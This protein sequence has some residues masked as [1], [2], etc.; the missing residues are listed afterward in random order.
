VAGPY[1]KEVGRLSIRVLPNA[2]KLRF[3]LQKQINRI[4]RS[5]RIE[6]DVVAKTARAQLDVQRF[7]D[8]FDGRDIGMEVQANTEV[9]RAQIAALARTRTISLAVRVR[10][11]TVVKAGAILAQ[12]TGARVVTGLM[13]DLNNTLSNLDKSVG[14]V[15]RMA[16]SISSLTTSLLS[17]SA[18]LITT[19]GDLLKMV[20]VGLVLP[21]ALTG[22]V[23]GIA[24]LGIALGDAKT[25]LAELLPAWESVRNVIRENFW[26]QAK[27]PIV[28]FVNNLLPAFRDGFGATA[29]AIGSQVGTLAN[30]FQRTLGGGV[31]E[32]LFGKLTE[33]ID[34]VTT[35]MKPLAE[36]LTTLGVVGSSY[37]P[38][39]A[40]WMVEIGNS[41]N[42][43]VQEATA[44]GEIFD[45]IE[46]GIQQIKY[47][48]AAVSGLA[49]IF[50]G[51]NSASEAAGFGGLQTFAAA[52]Q[53]AA[54][55]IQSP[56]VQ[57][58]LT[59]ILSG[60]GTAF[61]ALGG[62]LSTLGATIIKLAPV[63][64][65]VLATAGQ[66][67]GSFISAISRA[68]ENKGFTD[69]LLALFDGIKKGAA[70]LEPGL[71]PLAE[72]FGALMTTVGMLAAE[73]G[74]LIAALK[75]AFAPVLET[76]LQVLQPL[77]PI[78]GEAL[79][80]AVQAITPFIEGLAGFIQDNSDSFTTLA[81]V[82]LVLIPAIGLGVKAFQGFGLAVKGTK[83]VMDGVT[84]ARIVA[85][86]GMDVVKAVG[87]SIAA[88]GKF[89]A[90]LATV[91]AAKAADLVL[92]ARIAAMYAADMVKGLAATTAALVKQGAQWVA[93]QA[94]MVAAKAAAAGVAAADLAKS[95]GATTAALVKQ[96]AAWV[97]QKAAM[98]AAKVA[99]VAMTVAQGAAA[100]AQRLLNAAMS[101][102]PIGI[103]ITLIAALVAGLIWFFTQTDAGKAIFAGFMSFISD[104]IA[105]LKVV[106]DAFWLGLGIIVDTVFN[107][108][109][110]AI[111][112]YVTGMTIIFTAIGTTIM[113]IWTT[114][115]DGLV[116]IVTAVWTAITTVITA[117]I[118]LVVLVITTVATTV[119]AIWQTLW[120][121]FTT[122]VSIVWAAII[123]VV[124]AAIQAVL[125]VVLT[126]AS[127][128]S[129]YW[130][131]IWTGIVSVVTTI[132]AAISDVVSSA[133]K[134][135]QT[136]IANVIGIIQAIWS[137]N[138]SAIGAYVQ[139]IWNA[140]KSFI[141]TAI[142]AV[143]SVVSS[144]MNAVA[145]VWNS[146]WGGFTR[147]VNSVWGGIQG[148]VSG[149]V[150]G[151]RGAI[152]GVFDTVSGIQARIVGILSGAGQWLLG[153][154]RAIVEG[155]A[156]GIKAAV[157]KATSAISGVLQSVRDFL[158]FSPA[159]RGPFS[160]KGWTPHSGLA[161]GEG[162]AEG[163]RNSISSV[164]KSADEMLNAASGT[165]SVD[166][167][168]TFDSIDR[169][170]EK[171]YANQP[172]YIT[173]NGGVGY[174]PASIA[175]EIA[176]RKRQAALAAGMTMVQV[177]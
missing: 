101:A 142:N 117:Y 9:A 58:G 31:L 63:I 133:I 96:G 163:I 105:N 107:A 32:G 17:L 59:T 104:A 88:F 124:S 140:I 35:G 2:S 34:I 57:T 147:V 139:N 55:I 67:V 112:L 78:F 50:R 36:A 15:S 22:A 126:V 77:I 162:L 56:A 130:N 156:E 28:D 89:V 10:E 128:I 125:S 132:W 91:A 176:L 164:R 114:F 119:V 169:A 174:D 70:G 29:T 46:D 72:L 93:N 52:L 65:T 62:G 167:D 42:T 41:F 8:E 73:F 4:E 68:L 38:R 108:I 3:D 94:K 19:S 20:N 51:L 11:A 177:A 148:V 165:A 45:I 122:I 33:S 79:V 173:I 103:I 144:V 127:A 153:S 155:L 81:G 116:G 141:Q 40:T 98:V 39:F 120:S 149:I 143:L 1:G 95:I 60:A 49:G 12:L 71:A 13:Q 27:A 37:L 84:T 100:I 157:G 21:A 26:D 6:L 138:W 134:T 106:W 170:R 118:Q 85:M 136:I 87:S 74:P 18:G 154:G 135:V 92:S 175:K 111:N 110:T 48:A 25:R 83:A 61:D 30:E 97:A 115:W 90:K 14:K 159:K 47:A 99:Q 161:L 129:N 150:G 54:A 66:T 23:V 171:A 151:V 168:T 131:A 158:P 102:N 160:G 43:W 145:G 152:Q 7:V 113:A 5:M 172:D 69:G 166:L 82:L 109:S 146:I 44:S 16:L 24:T 53:G 137:G 76:I 86:Y 75:I 64:S 80:G 121:G 123:G